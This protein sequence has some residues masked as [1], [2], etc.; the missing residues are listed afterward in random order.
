[1]KRTD[2]GSIAKYMMQ[3]AMIA[4]AINKYFLLRF[5]N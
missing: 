3:T 1:M 4:H 5:N 2:I